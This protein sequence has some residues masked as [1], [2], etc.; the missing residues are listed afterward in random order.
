[1]ADILEAGNCNPNISMNISL[2]GSNVFQSGQRHHALHDHR[3]RQRRALGLRRHVARG[4]I[5]RTEA[6]TA[7]WRC[8]TS[9]CSRRPSRSACAARST[10]TS[11][12]RTRSPA[13]PPLTTQFSNTS[14]S[15]KFR[16]IAL[17]I[18]AREA[19]CM[20]RQTF[21]VEVG[22]W[23]HHDEVILNQATMLPVVSRALS[24]FASALTELD[25]VDAGDDVHRVGLRPHAELERPRLGPRVGREPHGDG[26]RGRRRRHLRALPRP[27][28][29]QLARH[30]A[31]AA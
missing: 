26:R 8:T 1:M 11:T 4:A 20:K 7:C 19:L 21:F 10:R 24:E 29:G 17:T 16:M 31:A 27:L 13:L 12:S 15:R 25:V 2:S 9:T 28:P 3:E 5:V 30:R 6:S 22:G 14:L 18:A 23:D